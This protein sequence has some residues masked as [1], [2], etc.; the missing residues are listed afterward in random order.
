MANMQVFRNKKELKHTDFYKEIKSIYDTPLFI[1]KVKTEF[2][3]DTIHA[4]SDTIIKTV[5]NDT[6]Y[7]NLRWHATEKDKWYS[8][9]GDTR[10]KGNFDKFNTTITNLSVKN[11]ITLDV[12]EKDKQLKV[13]ARNTNPYIKNT[14]IKSVVIDP[15]KS[16]VLK[17]YFKPGRFSVGPYLGVGINKDM[18]V[19]PQIGVGITYTLFR[20]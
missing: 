17:E 13:L 20:F 11:D 16:K 12:I 1:T 2:R 10:V 14:E 15:S 5:Y 19:S 4:T 18:V 7:H 3:I 6:L 8:M 9:N